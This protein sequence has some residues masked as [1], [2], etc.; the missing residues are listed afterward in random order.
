MI[1]L[2]MNM[3]VRGNQVMSVDILLK[4]EKKA[5]FVEEKLKQY[6]PKILEEMEYEKCDFFAYNITQELKGCPSVE[7]NME[8]IDDRYYP[9]ALKD[10]WN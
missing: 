5:K 8:F 2:R 3:M 6:L 9:Q 1:N 10:L 7:R 4:D